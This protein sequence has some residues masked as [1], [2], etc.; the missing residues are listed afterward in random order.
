MPEPGIQKMK[1]CVLHAAIVPVHRKPV[2]Q[3][4]LTGQ[5]FCILRVCITQEIPGRACP[6]RHGV[7]LSFCRAAAAGACGIHPVCYGSQGGFS[8]IGR[9]IAVHFRQLQR[10]FTFRQRH[11][12]AFFAVYNG[13]RLSPVTLTGKYPV[14]QLEIR[15]A[16]SYLFF[17]QK[18]NYFLFGFC[19]FQSVQKSGIHQLPCGNVRVG[20]FL[21]V[22]AAC[23]HFNN[24]KAELLCKFPVTGI[25]S[26]NCHDG[27]CTVTHQHII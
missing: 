20:F 8:G 15:L 17:F 10:K 9:H 22:L 26:R 11:I 25:M 27:T 1:G 23:H 6:L 14:S 12:T 5:S 19:H 24:G 18:F 4:L 21:Y 7:R 16:F 2:F 13:N 3:S